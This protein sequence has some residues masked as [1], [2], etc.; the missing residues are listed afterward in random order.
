MRTGI[1]DMRTGI[2]RRLWAVSL[3]VEHDYSVFS[4]YL[5]YVTVRRGK[6][7]NICKTD[8]EQNERNNSK[9]S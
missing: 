4:S 2:L 3:C 1:Q 6:L 9:G 8:F 5:H 7:P